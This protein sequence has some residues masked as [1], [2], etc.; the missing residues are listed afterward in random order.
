MVTALQAAAKPTS[1]AQLKRE[2]G[3][4]ISL[5]QLSWWADKLAAEGVLAADE[6]DAGS[7]LGARAYSPR[8]R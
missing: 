1:P 5:S 3:T 4:E 2:T 8:T 7:G 6:T